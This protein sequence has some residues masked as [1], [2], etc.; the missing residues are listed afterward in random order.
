M[1]AK[2]MSGINLLRATLRENRYLRETQEE[3]SSL[4]VMDSWTLWEEPCLIQTIS[5]DWT[6]HEAVRLWEEAEPQADLCI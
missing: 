2:W 4:Y 5:I 3:A 1:F 6:L